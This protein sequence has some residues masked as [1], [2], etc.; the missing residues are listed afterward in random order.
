MA[1]FFLTAL[2]VHGI[3][4]GVQL[5]TKHANVVYTFMFAMLFCQVFILIVGFFGGK[6]F[7]RI[8]DVP[9]KILVPCILVLAIVGAYAGR[10]LLFDIYLL[11]GFGVLGYFLT[12]VNVPLAPFVLA[13]VLGPL[14][15]TQFRRALQILSSGIGSALLKPLP[16]ALLLI[17]IGLLLMPF[18]NFRKKKPVE[19]SDEVAS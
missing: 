14:I 18:I 2:L 13:F 9:T 11:I 10:Y 15:E 3:Y 17:N 1:I 19:D 4:P 5:F 16:L 7:A 6:F 8:T 12:R